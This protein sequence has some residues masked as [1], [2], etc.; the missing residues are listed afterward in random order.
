MSDYRE[1]ERCDRDVYKEL[2]RTSEDYRDAEENIKTSRPQ[3]A[4]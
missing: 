2:Q 3:A 4:A 1:A